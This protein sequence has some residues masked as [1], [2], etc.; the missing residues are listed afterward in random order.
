MSANL[1]LESQLN[2]AVEDGLEV[3]TV[4][5]ETIVAGEGGFEVTPTNSIPSPTRLPTD[6]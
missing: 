1:H 4:T 5:D 2:D 3:A 6:W